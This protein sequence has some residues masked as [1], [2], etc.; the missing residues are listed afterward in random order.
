MKY[1]PKIHHRRS[2]R[3]KNYDYSSNGAYFITLSTI[4]REYYFEKFAELKNI[5]EGQWEK[6]PE[7]FE[8]VEI[9]EFVVMPNHVHGLFFIRA[10]ARP[11]RAD[12]RPAR[13]AVAEAELIDIKRKV[14][15][16]DIVC[17][18]KSLCAVEWLKYIKANNIDAP[19]KFWQRNYYESI[20]RDYRH[21]ENVRNYIKN[22][23]SKW[24]IEKMHDSK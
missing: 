1:N 8:D 7:R 13:T 19:G 12:A 17:A 4:D 6:L 14:T 20:I 15:V 21:L 3:L 23:P 10:D 5:L 22:N 24:E 9:D 18:Y 16:G 2:I 11:E